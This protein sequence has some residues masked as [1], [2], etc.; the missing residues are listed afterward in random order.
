M[1]HSKKPAP[2]TNEIVIDQEKNVE[3]LEIY[4]RRKQPLPQSIKAEGLKA[5]EITVANDNYE[6]KHMV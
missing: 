2:S 4:C 5:Q 1:S 6:E 3:I